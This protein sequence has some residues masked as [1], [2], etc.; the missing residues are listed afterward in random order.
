MERT[1]RSLSVDDVG[2]WFV[3]DLPTPGTYTVTASAPGLVTNATSVELTAGPGAVRDDVNLRLVPAL[4]T[5]RGR[6]TDLDRTPIGGVAITLEGSGI[7]RRTVSSDDPAGAYVID[8]IPAGV[9]TL[10]FRRAGST[11]QTLLVDLSPGEEL[12]LDPVR[13]EEQAIVTG[14]V[15][16]NNVG[17]SDV[18]VLV[19]RAESYPSGLVTSTVTGPGGRYTIVGLD[20]PESY[21][22]EF[23]VPAGGPVAGSRVVVLQP[24]ETFTLDVD[25]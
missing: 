13:L 9:Y 3:G 4:A 16:R 15:R 19:Y 18:G 22:I 11:A 5:V 21:I 10:T 25:L 8:R 2:R 17:A 24:D 1:T 7:E 6:V 12:A 14:T 20:A 23:Q